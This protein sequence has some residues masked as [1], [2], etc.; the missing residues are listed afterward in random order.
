MSRL[1]DRDQ[2]F[3]RDLG[4][5][6]TFDPLKQLQDVLAQKCGSTAQWIHEHETFQKWKD[7]PSNEVLWLTGGPGSGKTVMA[8]SII[9]QLQ[10]ECD[11]GNSVLLYYFVD[12]KEAEKSNPLNVFPGLIYQLLRAR[13]TLVDMVRRSTG[14]DAYFS[15]TMEKSAKILH[16][17]IKDIP[18]IFLFVDAID[19]CQVSR[20]ELLL[21]L[22]DLQKDAKCLKLFV[23]SRTDPNC[24]IEGLFDQYSTPRICLTIDNTN[25]DIA[26]YLAV[27][28][29]KFHMLRS[30]NDRHGTE[31]RK[32]KQKIVDTILKD[33][34]GMF[35]YASMA[36]STFR[37]D[38]DRWDTGGLER[39]FR[40]LEALA[41][42]G[43]ATNEAVSLPS[44][45]LGIL[46]MLPSVKGAEARTK[47][48]FQWL[49]AAHKTLTLAE[50]RDA[51]SLEFDDTSRAGMGDT[52]LEAFK[53]V[54][55]QSCGA[56]I[57]IT[58]ATQTVGLYH[59]SI[60]EF[61]MTTAPQL[62][63]FT[64]VEAEIH[65]STAC[66]TYL[67]FTDL[68]K[69]RPGPRSARQM[70]KDDAQLVTDFP[71]L[72]YATL[73]WP[74]HVA[75]VSGDVHLWNLFVSWA[76]SDN[77][78]LW[79]RIYWEI[80]G[81]GDCP[82]DATQLHVVSYLG[83]EYFVKIALSGD[84]LL[85]N[86]VNTCDSLNRTPLHWAAI[87]GHSGIVSILVDSGAKTAA[88]DSSGLTPLELALERGNSDAVLL[89]MKGCELQ[90]HW[91]EMAVIGGHP[92]AVQLLLDRGAGVNSLSLTTKYGSALHA[93]AYRGNEQ[94]VGVLLDASAD[95]LFFSDTYGTAL[96]VAVFRGHLGVVKLLIDK[97]ADVNGKA[98][99]S[100]TAL[101]AA[102]QRGFPEIVKLLIGRGAHVDTPPQETLGTALY[103]AKSNGHRSIV[104]ILERAGALCEGPQLNRRESVV[105]PIVEYR[106]RLTEHGIHRGDQLV[107]RGQLKLF[108]EAMRYAVVS[109]SERTVALELAFA[110]PYFRAS[111][112][113][114]SET[115]M[116]SLL[117][118]GFTVAR[119][120]VKAQNPRVLSMIIVTWTNAI[121][122]A[123]NEGKSSFV[124]RALL[125]CIA[126]LKTCIDEHRIEDAK[127]LIT[128]GVEIL[129]Q[130][131]RV[132]HQELIELL[133]KV[134]AG[135]VNDA[136]KGPFRESVFDIAEI[137]GE[138][139][140]KAAVRK[141]QVE[142]RVLGNLAV[143]MLLAAAGNAIELSTQL[144]AW[145]LVKLRL[146]LSPTNLG[147]MNWLLHEG[148]SISA[149]TLGSNDNV[150]A[151]VLVTVAMQFF[152]ALKH[153][154][155]GSND[156][157]LEK[158]LLGI[159]TTVLRGI[160][161]AGHLESAKDAIERLA[162]QHFD[163]FCTRYRRKEELVE[164]EN[165]FLDILDLI[166]EDGSEIPSLQATVKSL[167]DAIAAYA[168]EARYDLD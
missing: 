126:K 47:K 1:S 95:V 109:Q 12:G 55:R 70:R 35:L 120:A 91:L 22:F 146:V 27:E 168:K 156:E 129:I 25:A 38:T 137:Y 14:T 86:M 111:L 33:A 68:T 92:A 151:E 32:I 73:Q 99:R 3:L 161:R 64:R 28:M 65:C 78:A 2:V 166:S 152:L 158:V 128:V 117:D 163:L 61:F 96:E 113:L 40:C 45:Y 60:R 56:F 15:S 54:L 26:V 88:M 37:D 104:D 134:W 142:V 8:G 102:A 23:T 89:L 121:L 5:R 90:D 24:T 114:A 75:Q 167:Q 127:N 84:G 122:I 148:E 110:I 103:L 31:E 140:V 83:L 29:R 119:D 53:T 62:Y 19:E 106:I 160:E 39:R 76:N 18:K 149:V 115:F 125:G 141:D 85:S 145:I 10:K 139:W 154:S 51:F 67:S 41:G 107:V 155:P 48:L 108:E 130:A 34:A 36:W 81:I 13:P 143:E 4:S 157:R 30:D 131:C 123:M 98:G 159:S 69:A 112:R 16:T 66:L 74:H 77:L 11:A 105:D 80:N 118:V 135:G 87:N 132:G 52:S 63:R 17:I 79:C 59:Q 138:I 165:H 21:Q 6:H 93:A 42:G 101:Q 162:N 43:T 100:G 144:T 71:L 57:I 97:G 49:V 124:E 58:N 164:L 136:I 153:R 20:S 72:E 9:D 50:L 7:S 150:Q 94:I 133:A 116:M 82:S 147:L 44:F 46:K